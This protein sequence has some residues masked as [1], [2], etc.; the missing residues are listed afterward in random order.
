MY[1]TYC[2]SFSHVSDALAAASSNKA[3]QDLIEGAASKGP[4]L[5]ALL[6]RPVQRMC[7]YPLLFKQALKY[8]EEGTPLHAKLTEVF[9][10]VQVTIMEVNE[11]VRKQAELD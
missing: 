7:V 1:S 5:E 8:V 10:S 2:A 11:K 4:A 3:A 9:D 6:F